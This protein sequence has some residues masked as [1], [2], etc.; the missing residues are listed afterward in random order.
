MSQPAD[1]ARGCGVRSSDGT[2]RKHNAEHGTSF[3]P[4]VLKN[5]G[6][7]ATNYYACTCGQSG[8]F[9]LW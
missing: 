6:A 1:Y 5:K 2:H 9:P 8:K 4:Q 3:K 7:N